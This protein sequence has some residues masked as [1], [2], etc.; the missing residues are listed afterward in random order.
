MTN[1]SESVRFT[2]NHNDIGTL[3]FQQ[4]RL[5]VHVPP[6]FQLPPLA[7]AEKGWNPTIPALL[8]YPKRM[9]CDKKVLKMRRKPSYLSRNR[10]TDIQTQNQH[11]KCP[12]PENTIR[13]TNSAESNT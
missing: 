7:R 8:L 11:H 2:T 10:Q 6:M 3:E 12:I 5:Y 4:N 9:K 13:I 1:T